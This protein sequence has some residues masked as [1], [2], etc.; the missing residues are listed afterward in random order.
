VQKTI[1]S[2]AEAM[3]AGSAPR[4]PW[5][6]QQRVNRA[7]S[8]QLS[9]DYS[10]TERPVDAQWTPIE[11][12]LQWA[13]NGR[14]LGVQWAFKFGA[15]RVLS[16]FLWPAAIVRLLQRVTHFC[17]MAYSAV[18]SASGRSDLILIVALSQ[19]AVTGCATSSDCT[20]R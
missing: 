10:R 12:P 16:L 4:S 14:S 7:H 5:H 9:A 6:T 18:T 13:S 8:S 19:A 11:R 1:R 2:L 17:S 3:D 15:F 20:E